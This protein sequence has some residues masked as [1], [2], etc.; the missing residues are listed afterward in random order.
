MKQ[1]VKLLLVAL[2]TFTSCTS[3]R[4]TISWK[5]PDAQQK[6]YKKILVLGLLREKDHSL[7]SKIEEHIAGDLRNLGYDA[8]CSCIEYSPKTFENVNEEEAIKK[9]TGGGIDAVLTV[10]LLDKTKERYY[11]PRRI[12]NTPYSIYYDHWWGYYN[13]MYDRIYENGYYDVSTK[14]FWESNFYDLQTKQLVYS[15][16]TESFDPGSAES[17]A[18]EYGKLIVSN[19]VKNKVLED[20]TKVE[21]MRPM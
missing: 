6:K 11:I 13:T 18:H 5:S 15:A 12:I 8:T 1:V 7:R 14:Y 20:Q 9:L 19:M 17:L 21:S 4:I 3:S 10:V 16:Q 2:F